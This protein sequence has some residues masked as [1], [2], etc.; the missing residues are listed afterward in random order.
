LRESAA[1]ACL[2]HGEEQNMR[3][4]I[5]I[6][7]MAAAVLGLSACAQTTDDQTEAESI[8]AKSRWTVEQF[9]AG[10][11]D[12]AR[13][14]R[15]NLKTAEGV[16]VLPTVTKGAFFFGAEGGNGVL[17][18]RQE[19]GTWS[20]PAFYTL[21]AGSFGLQMGGQ[22]A[23]VIL[24]L[25]SRDAVDAVLNHQGKFGGDVQVT[26]GDV[27]AGLEA[28][29]TANLGADVVGFSHAQGLFAGISLEGAVLGRRNDLNSAYY[30]YS[31]LSPR[32]IARGR[33][34]WNVQADPLRQSLLLEQPGAAGA[35]AADAPRP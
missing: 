13:L 11:D 20:Y 30:G 1:D 19:D 28:A 16:V 15:A 31:R 6:A 12:A 3:F 17:L 8:V 7:A 34:A 10:D 5:A 33:A 21:G 32:A 4:A 9:L 18:A 29:T 26:L 25:R 2:A 35:Q 24:V 14:F 27:G 23:E 22:S